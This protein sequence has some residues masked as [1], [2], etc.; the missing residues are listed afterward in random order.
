MKYPW[1][2][3]MIGEAD[4]HAYIYSDL[5]A[6]TVL[7]SHGIGSREKAFVVAVNND[8]DGFKWLLVLTSTG[9]LG[10]TWC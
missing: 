5:R 7:A 8:T 9:V 4:L 2:G 3:D 1:P 6:T 10:W